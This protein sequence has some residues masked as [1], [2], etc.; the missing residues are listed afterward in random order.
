MCVCVYVYIY[1][2]IYI[3]KLMMRGPLNRGPLQI[4]MVYATP[5]FFRVFVSC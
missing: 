4:P 1:I 5:L 3:Y 2:Y